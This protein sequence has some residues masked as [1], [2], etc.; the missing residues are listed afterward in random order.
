MPRSEE[1]RIMEDPLRP[2]IVL[3]A[4]TILF[5]G[6]LMLR[7]L[8]TDVTIFI[9]EVKKIKNSTEAIETTTFSTETHPCLTGLTIRL[10]KL[11]LFPRGKSFQEMTIWKLQI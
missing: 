5:A 9:Q 1:I 11:T 2:I 4:I 7:D 8:L 6:L 3:M 10:I